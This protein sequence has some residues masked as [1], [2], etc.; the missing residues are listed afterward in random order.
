METRFVTYRSI[1]RVRQIMAIE[2]THAT[3]AGR[4]GEPFV[5]SNAAFPNISV[6]LDEA[7]DLRQTGLKIPEHIRQEPFQLTFRGPREPMLP[8]GLYTLS[9]ETLGE[10]DLFVIPGGPEGNHQLY[11]VTVN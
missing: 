10:I 5:L 6:E 8:Q 11:N 4:I 2:L 7:I 3:F 9:H 1:T